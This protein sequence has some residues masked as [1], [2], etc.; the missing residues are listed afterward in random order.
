MFEP[1]ELKNSWLTY[2]FLQVESEQKEK[3]ASRLWDKKLTDVT[4]LEEIRS[5]VDAKETKIFCTE[6]SDG[7]RKKLLEELL[8]ALNHF[9]K[10]NE[11]SL[12]LLHHIGKC[13]RR[14]KQFKESIDY[15]SQAISIDEKFYPSY[16]QIA[17]CSIQDSE[18]SFLEQGS[19]AMK[20]I[21]ADIF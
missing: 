17:K 16:L 20:Y 19:N 4:T 6:D 2:G 10:Q 7:E 13:Y 9:S 3:I 12:I 21:L 18:K 5:L 14:L 8:E 1:K 11:I 15:L